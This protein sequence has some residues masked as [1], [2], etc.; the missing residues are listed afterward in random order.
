MNLLVIEEVSRVP[1]E[2]FYA[3]RPMLAVS[4]GTLVALSTPWGKRGWFYEAW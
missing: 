4:G 3:V 2:L 1:D